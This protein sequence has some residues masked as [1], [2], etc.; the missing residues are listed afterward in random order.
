MTIFFLEGGEDSVEKMWSS[1]Y[2]IAD[3]IHFD[4]INAD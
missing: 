1:F 3:A 2:G 4:D